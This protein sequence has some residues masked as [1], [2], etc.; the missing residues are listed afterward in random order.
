MT[1]IFSSKRLSVETKAVKLP[2]GIE[3][4]MLL[5]RPRD[6]VAVLPIDET[7]C[8]LIRQYRFAV[9]GY[10]VEAP[11][12]QIDDGETPEAAVRRELAEETGLCAKVFTPLG[13]IYTT[14]GFTTERIYLFE[15]RDLSAADECNGDDDEIIDLLPVRRYEVLQMIKE[16]KIV[17]AKTICLAHRCL[18]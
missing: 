14:P 17:D 10:I 7:Y 2:N 16:G 9:D 11:A 4:E 3:R 15:A 5:V 6:A 12:G 1:E 18:R 8:Y 13:Y